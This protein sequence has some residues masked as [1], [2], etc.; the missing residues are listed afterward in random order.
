M[1]AVQAMMRA[2][3][4]LAAVALGLATPAAAAAAV[5]AC[6]RTLTA[7]VVV[8]DQPLM[9]NRLGSQNVNGIMYALRRDV[10]AIPAPG[11]PVGLPGVG[12]SPGNVMLRPD[13]RPRPL[14]V[15]ASAGDCLTVNFQNLLAPVANPR[16]LPP[17]M[18]VDDQVADRFAGFHAQGMQLRT[19]VAD[20]GSF[21]GKNP[22]SLVAPGGTAAYNLFAEHEGEFLVTSHGATFGG[23]GLAGN[24][25]NGMFAVVDVEPV[26]AKFYR[27]QVTEE[28]LRLATVGHTADGQPIVDYEAT[29][30]AT[31]ADGTPSIWAREGKAG[32]PILN[33]VDPAGNL[34]HTD[35]NAVVVGPNADGS[36]PPSTYP[37]ERASNGAK[38]NPTV[39][40]RLEPFREFTVAFHDEMAV[41]NAFP[42]W[43]LDPVLGHTLHAVG[44]VFQIN[45]GSGAIG[46]E[47]IASRLSVGP[48]HDCVDCVYEEFFLTSPTVG[49]PAMVVD[50]P[51]NVGLEN[52]APPGNGA[53]CTGVDPAT[54]LPRNGPKA[55]EAFYPDDPSNV[56][57][58]YTND[59]V[60]FRNVHTGKEHHIFHLH[61]HQWLFNASDDNANYLD[62]Q[63]IGPGAGYTYEIN[64]GGSGNRNKTA[65]DAIFHCHFYPH[66]AMG[67]WELWRVHDVLE[68]GTPLAVS[69]GAASFHTVPYALQRGEPALLDPAAGARARALPDGEIAAGT[70][71]P[72]LVPLPGKPMAPTPGRVTVVPKVDN[73]FTVGSLARVD[74]TDVL[75]A[76][77]PTAA[78]IKAIPGVD[79]QP[80]NPTGLK[81]PGFPFWV[82][83]MEDTVG[84]RNPTP[85]LDMYKAAGGWDGGLPRHALD[86]YAASGC[87]ADHSQCSVSVQSRFDMTKE[88][89]KAAPVWF[90]E[91]GNDVEKAAMSFHAVR[92]HP[93]FAL[94]LAP[95]ADGSRTTPGDFITNGSG[96]P[97]PGAPF[98]EPCVDDTGHPLT[99]GYV[100]RFFSA[101]A[102]NPA[103][104]TDGL[105]I[106]GSSPFNADTP[107]VYKGV[108]IQFDAV[109]NKLGYHFPQERIITLWQ[110]A[111]PTI[112][113]VRP[114]EP[115]LM[116]INTFDCTMYH[117]SNLVPGVYELDD[118]EIRTTTDIIGQHIHLPKWDLTTTDGSANGWNY[119]DGTLSPDTVRE[120]IH[121]INTFNP[122]GA[123]NPT[124]SA[125]R[126]ANTPLL[127]AAHPFFGPTSPGGVDWKGAR[128]T[129]QRWFADPVVNVDGQHRGLGIIFSHDHF[130]PSTHQQIGL[131]STVLI[132]PPGSTWKHNETGVALYTRTGTPAATNTAA[133]GLDGGP[134]SWQ[135]AILRGGAG[136]AV[137]VNESYREFY[138]EY[139][140]FQHAYA[141]GVYVGRSQNGGAVIPP[142]ADTFRS[143]VN[144]SN[145]QQLATPF[146]DLV[147]FPPTCPGGVPR[148]CPE[149]ITADDPGFFVVN[150]R[151]E[152]VGF[153][154]FDP[155]KLGPDGQ[156]GAQ[157][158]GLAGDLAFAL[159]S[160]TDR[161]LAPLNVQP[162]LGTTINGTTFPSPINAIT[163]LDPGDPFT[164]MLRVYEGDN[165][166]V[167]IQAGGDE[168]SHSSTING[169][170]WLQGGSGFGFAPN[171]GWR[172]S[173]HAGISE[174]FTFSAPA[175][176]L[177]NGNGGDADHLYS[178]NPS[179]DGYW[180]GTWGILRN[181]SK[182]RADLF[183]MPNNANLPIKI[184]NGN[185]FQGACPKAAV[186]RSYDVTVALAND[187]LANATGA[188]IVPAGP[189]ATMHVG[190]PLNPNGGTLVYNPRPS[191]VTGIIP[192]PGGEGAAG[193]AFSKT[194]PLHDP[195]GILYVMT[196]DLV[197][198]N[199]SDPACINPTTLRLDPTLYGCP[200]KLRET[201]CTPAGCTPG[202][203][204]EPIVLRAV[205][206][207]CV[208][209]LLR[210]KLPAVMPD[211]A[212]WK[213]L[214]YVVKRLDDPIQG[215]TTFNNNL[216]RASSKVG[217][218]TQLLAFD[219]TKD[220]GMVVGLNG[221]VTGGVLVDP[222]RTKKYQ[223]YAGD[224]SFN[225]PGGNPGLVAT[226]IEFG[227]ANIT[228]ADPMK[229]AP[230]G[231]V[232]AVSVV[233]AASTFVENDVVLDHQANNMTADCLTTPAACR[234]TR[235][236][237]TVNGAI[238]D[239]AVVTQKG[240][241]HRWKDGTPVEQIAAEGSVS[242]DTEDSGQMSINY[243][244][245]PA[246]FRFGIPPNSPFGPPVQPF[247]NFAAVPN[248][249]E[250]Y[251]NALLDK[252]G[253]PMGDPATPVFTANRGAE[254]RMHLLEPTGS[255]RASLI[256]L[257]GH[258][259]Q[260]APY[261]CPGVT[262][263]GILGKCPQR[264]SFYVPAGGNP[265]STAI[266]DSAISFYLGQEDLMQPTEHFTLRLPSAGGAFQVPGD[267]LLQDRSGFGN[268]SGQWGILRVK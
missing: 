159:Q 172:N 194:G 223:W 20:D 88:I 71:I 55:T 127:A 119:E 156:N 196:S 66:F 224:I 120:R 3:L 254:T 35:L 8:F 39:P 263:N 138:F 72:A 161:K 248:A 139:S 16:A 245:E 201:V 89:T 179:L 211:L 48:M 51:A 123:G 252:A 149:A 241:E 234:R 105:G 249:H 247:T 41:A 152:G 40:N 153:R 154:V 257:H 205:A 118:Y 111:V 52:C 243:G 244:S 110:D 126:P 144:P 174:Q 121:A 125:G 134:T 107:R 158:D 164:P 129:L 227:G 27:S 23:E 170:K 175:I 237:A 112:N 58:S 12:L 131:Y 173:Q 14:V 181:Y 114:P 217:I 45:Y 242:E 130:G 228:P 162:V 2:T 104:G 188:T 53:E 267:Y 204:V 157:A 100:G 132:E 115:F 42:R 73:G 145:K 266:G 177:L 94:R 11:Q 238:R 6:S 17:P 13:K 95:A 233:P 215:F 171:S 1:T 46:N 143:A 81:N 259:W 137:S 70:P 146:P 260:R 193:V 261:V 93:S 69:G 86:G 75:P 80:I 102:P 50:I 207:E 83:G 189:T 176:P 230:K 7:D 190:G 208:N 67:M 202:A 178:V 262:T 32:A 25:S 235:Q 268:A 44:D 186:V 142:T 246:W 43:F 87:G 122:T 229:Q 90:D 155:N 214:P 166:R 28:E 135:A 9:Y 192:G 220:D 49:D 219:V 109:L 185:D 98:H 101:D 78:Q 85:P 133:S 4:A 106:A 92:R 15:R 37:I 184:A 264:N 18:N 33:M 63:G 250:Y 59:F 218:H 140:D 24:S 65:G 169:V 99:A 191:P 232:G 97:V 151:N 225:G 5:P 34:V 31:N 197:A 21:V 103:L 258:V 62:A 124:D 255:N 251:S 206:G 96:R 36:F 147:V 198:R 76:T 231:L 82:G 163:A 239:L 240:Q 30:P 113:K 91:T 84:N 22:S 209:V 256:T 128:T 77:D 136:D 148:P 200:V 180:N 47:V 56:H 167:K 253:N 187:V 212:S 61:N 19:S 57:H 160:R 216:I 213:T 165:V 236:S 10:V 182:A 68:A 222:G 74:R 54:G 108:N 183:V 60:K 168:E 141:P 117:H 210:N 26:G 29:Y 79:G 203:P 265:G 199:A 195:T 226:A 64:F 150:Y 221:G 38:R 116:R